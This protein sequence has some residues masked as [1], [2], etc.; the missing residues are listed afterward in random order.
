MAA[1]GHLHLDY[2]VRQYLAHRQAFD[3]LHVPASTATYRA[4]ALHAARV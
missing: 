2:M 1:I 3:V 4:D